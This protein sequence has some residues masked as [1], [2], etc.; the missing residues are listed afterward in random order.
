MSQGLEEG[1]NI[2]ASARRVVALTGAGISAESGIAPFRGSGGIWSR[3]D[4]MEYGTGEALRQNPAKVWR[5]L[6]ALGNE[7]RAAEPNPAH[8]ALAHAETSG[9]WE[10]LTIVTQNVDGLHQ[11]AGSVHVVELHGSGDRLIC[12][13]CAE[14]R[15]AES[16]DVDPDSLPPRCHCGGV[17][18]PDVVLFGETLPPEA[19]AEAE[20]ATRRADAVLIVGTSAEVVPASYLPALARQSGARLVEINPERTWLS[21]SVVDLSI[22]GR[23]GEI[24]PALMSSPA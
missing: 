14:E 7:I 9:R 22:P 24:L 10:E 3:F 20:A 16:L 6:H 23:A 12:M 13:Q 21:D 15:S 17:L 11:R 2:L 1:R 5:M 18:R 4:P 8:R 19:W